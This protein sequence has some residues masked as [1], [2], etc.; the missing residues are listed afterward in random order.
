MKGK[1]VQFPKSDTYSYNANK[2]GWVKW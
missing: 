2:R 1:A